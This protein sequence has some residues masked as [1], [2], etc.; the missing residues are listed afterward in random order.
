MLEAIEPFA[1]VMN[2]IIKPVYTGALIVLIASLATSQNKSLVNCLTAS[3]LRWPFMLVANMM[4]SFLIFIGIMLFILP[5]IWLISRLFLVPYLV[6]LKNQS[7]LD[8]V[9]NSYQYTKGYSF[10]ILR[11]IVILIVIL[12]FCI[13]ILNFLNL[14]ALSL[15][16]LLLLLFQTM[17]HVIYYR[18]Y[19]ILIK[20][21]TQ[22]KG[23]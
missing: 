5:G 19:E 13:L 20:P 1:Q 18:H 15:L 7:P 22:A 3:I 21:E 17:A 9:I 8:A 16:L 2:I 12:M 11:D 4:T 10:T 14:L 6:M 23:S